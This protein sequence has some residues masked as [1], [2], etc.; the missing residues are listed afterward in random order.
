MFIINKVDASWMND[1]MVKI[2]LVG[3]NKKTFVFI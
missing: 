3:K 2:F 1:W